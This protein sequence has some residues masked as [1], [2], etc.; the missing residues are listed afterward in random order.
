VLLYGPPGTGKTLL[1][2]AVATE[3]QANFISVRGPELLSKWVG[4]SE[5][6]VRE[7]FRKA[8]ESAPCI[9]FFDE[10]DSIAPHRGLRGGD[11]GVTERVV[12]Q[13]LTEIDGII[14]LKDVVTIAATNR[15]DLLD[16]A[17][18]RP[19]R[20][21]RII[22]VPPPDREARLQ[23]FKVHTRK[24]PLSSE[25]N[26][27]ELA[28]KTEGYTGADIEA[29]CR[30]AAMIAIREGYKARKV[31]MKDFLKAMETIRPSI[32]PEDVERHERFAAHYR[33][34]MVQ[35]PPPLTIV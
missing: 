25:V 21:D 4:E 27:E 15:P 1:A 22:Y 9:I 33:K 26:L 6:G 5:K 12:N 29:L 14:V 19:G 24:M 35:N 16:Q 17:L 18:L 7:I 30:E 2:K 23:I 20:F 28:A 13:I 31:E 3:S 8:R 32:S 10:I 34:E 11:S